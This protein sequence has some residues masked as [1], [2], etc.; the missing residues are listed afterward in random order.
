M[1]NPEEM[2]LLGTE[3]QRHRLTE[4]KDNR[5]TSD[6]LHTDRRMKW[7][8]NQKGNCLPSFVFLW[9]MDTHWPSVWGTF[10]ELSL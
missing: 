3:T 10:Q 1:T 5:Q 7:R 6:K 9:Y 4:Q 2:S 8:I